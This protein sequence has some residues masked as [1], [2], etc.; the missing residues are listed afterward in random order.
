MD[1]V[2]CM[3]TRLIVLNVYHHKIN[4]SYRMKLYLLVLITM[5][6]KLPVSNFNNLNC[7]I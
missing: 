5:M 6:K 4:F 2:A 3:A 7:S 1:K